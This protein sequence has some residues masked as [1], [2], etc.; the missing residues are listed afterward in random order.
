MAFDKLK[1]TRV[2]NLRYKVD[3]LNF[4]A[5]IDC[6]WQMHDYGLKEQDVTP[7]EIYCFDKPEWDIR[8][9]YHK[10]KNNQQS[11][12]FGICTTCANFDEIMEETKKWIAQHKK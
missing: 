1:N 10:E 12:T 11:N 9:I 5:A 4:D 3:G 2:V 7:I 8:M 6:D